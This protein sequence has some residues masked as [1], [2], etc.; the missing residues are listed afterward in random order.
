[1]LFHQ[2]RTHL[3]KPNGNSSVAKDDHRQ[4]NDKLKGEHQSAV[5]ASLALVGAPILVAKLTAVLVD[6][7]QGL[8]KHYWHAEPHRQHAN[9][10]KK[11]LKSVRDKCSE[12][13][14][15]MY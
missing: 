1:M 13:V 12:F 7:P 2:K 4:R 6:G 9:Q 5:S 11:F 15:S 14:L 8:H 10:L 3:R